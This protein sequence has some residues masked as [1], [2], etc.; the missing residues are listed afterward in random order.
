[1]ELKNFSDDQ[2]IKELQN[3]GYI[4]VL[5]HRDDILKVAEENDIILN[6]DEIHFIMEDIE[7]NHDA[8]YGLNWD[9]ISMKIDDV[10]N[11][12]EK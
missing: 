6:E 8:N 10:V 9:D 7:E 12:R 2:L 3:R 4:R 1:M 11:N 5:W